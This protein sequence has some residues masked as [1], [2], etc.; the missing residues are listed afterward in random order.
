[1]SRPLWRDG[2]SDKFASLRIHLAESS[3]HGL[4]VLIELDRVNTNE[5][6]D[7]VT[8]TGHVMAGMSNISAL[9]LYVCNHLARI[10]SV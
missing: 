9:V 6:C 1:M 5:V 7:R 4:V 10:G 2:A 3:N 8:M